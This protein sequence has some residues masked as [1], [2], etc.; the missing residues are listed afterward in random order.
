MIQTGDQ[1]KI[2][3][4]DFQTPVELAQEVCQQ[5]IEI[6]VNPDVIIEPTCGVGNFIKTAARLFPSTEKII[7]VEINSDYLENAHTE[8]LFLEDNRIELKNAN[9]FEFNWLSYVNQLP[10]QILVLGN[11]PWVTSSQQGGIGGTNLPKKSNFQNH[12]GLDAITG[13]SNFDIS[14]WMLIQSIQ[15][16]QGRNAYLAMLC[17]TSV[18]RK[19]LGYLYS[20]NLNLADCASYSIDTKKYFDASVDACLFFC[21]FDS[22][23]KNYCCNVFSSLRSSEYYTIGYRHNLLIRDIV[24]F[25]KLSQLYDVNRQKKWRSGI[26]HDCS[27]VMELR[28]NNNSFVNGLGETVDIEETYVFPLMKGSDVAQNRIKNTDRYLLVTQKFVGESTESIQH[29][30]P[31]TWSYLESHA[32]YLDNRKSKIY[33]S[34]P[35]FSIF[36]V[37]AYTFQPWK[38]AICGLYK[39]LEFRLISHIVSKPV[40]F[41]DTVYFLSFDNEETAHKT[42]E[43]LN[44][45]SVIK[46]YSSLIFWDEK[47]PIKSSILNSLNLTLV[48]VGCKIPRNEKTMIRDWN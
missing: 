29:L 14:E 8:K 7:G 40:V 26:K 46:F 16:L 12:R 21:K 27:N 1:T 2:E 31:K 9:F 37:G 17:K 5:L 33:K 36:G 47:R 42:F 28:K 15:W 18:S 30:A 39:R 22:T 13:K 41:D 3:Y 32:S 34:N 20:N 4:G 25:E 48:K 10:G 44:S 45:P 19:L 43:M 35:K 6:G 24:S 23:S 11:F 38:I